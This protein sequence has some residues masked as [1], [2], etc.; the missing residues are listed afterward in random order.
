MKK[1]KNKEE[2]KKRIFSTVLLNGEVVEIIYSPTEEETWLV[3]SS[4]L[5]PQEYIETEK[6]AKL[7]PISPTN[8]LIATSFVKL[9]CDLTLYKSPKDLFDQVRRFIASHIKLP[10]D[11]VVVSAVYVMM[12][13]LYDRFHTVPYLRVIG[14]YGTGKSRFLEIMGHLCYKAITAGGS[15]S[16][17][18][19]FRSVDQIKGTLVFDE[20]DF[21]NSEMWSEIVKILNAGH[22]QGFPV[23]RMEKTGKDE[24]MKIRIFNVFGPKIL[25]SRERFGDEALESRCITQYIYPTEVADHMIS[26]NS[27]FR[28]EVMKIR[29]QLLAFRLDMHQKTEEDTTTLK[30]LSFP[31]LKQSALALTTTANLIGSDVLDVVLKFVADYEGQLIS[32]QKWDIKADVLLCIADII[33]E[34]ADKLMLNIYMSNIAGKFNEKLYEE[35]SDKKDKVYE[36]MEGVFREKQQTVSPKKIGGYVRKLGI[37]TERDHDGFYIPIPQESEKIKI[38]LKRYGFE[39]MSKILIPDDSKNKE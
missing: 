24:E 9:P 37:R 39:K 34:S 19:V 14:N 13:W 18:A 10:E 8:D 12:T 21:R 5:Q 29:N 16:T 35:Y 23:A 33:K 17:A 7:Y 26:P 36:T 11:F 30:G 22:T 31:R 32:N 6:G 38:L 15:I 20:A 1:Q 25:A 4:N 2:I 27:K 28:D 3:S